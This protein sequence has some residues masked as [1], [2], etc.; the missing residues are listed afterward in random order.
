MTYA[1]DWQRCFRRKKRYREY[2]REYA[3]RPE[4]ILRRRTN[5]KRYVVKNKDH[6]AIL[7]QKSYRKSRRR[8]PWRVLLNLAKKRARDRG[9][10]Y[11]LTP[12]WARDMYTGYC[13]VSGIK[14]KVGKVSFGPLSPTIDRVQ[15]GKGY[16]PKNCRFTLF[17]VNA[18]KGT[19]TDRK[20]RAI[21][22]AIT[23]RT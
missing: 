8:E 18:L 2:E 17:A 10:A 6:V 13:A 3:K 22:R 11:S 7:R 1:A 20:M 19:L 16:V 23:E 9:L 4:V 14:F 15:R 21:A 5:A 12:D